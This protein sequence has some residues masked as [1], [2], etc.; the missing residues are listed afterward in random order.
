MI[1]LTQQDLQ[2][3]EAILVDAPYKV[4]QPVLAILTKAIQSQQQAQPVQEPTVEG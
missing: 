4:A 2:Q 3:L 1:T